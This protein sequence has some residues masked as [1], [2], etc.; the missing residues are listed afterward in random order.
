MPKNTKQRA[1]AANRARTQIYRRSRSNRALQ[2]RMLIGL[3]I[4]VV[5]AVVLGLIATSGGTVSPNPSTSATSPPSPDDPQGL[6]AAATAHP[7]DPDTVGALAS[8]FD[9]TGQYDRA[10]SLYQHYL[11]LRPD[12]A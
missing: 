2:R 6:V 12:D 4:F 1:R 8:Y 5:L 9:Q 7:N 11:Q 3:G 10:L